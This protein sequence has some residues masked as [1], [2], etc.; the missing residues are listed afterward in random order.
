MHAADLMAML[1]GKHN[2]QDQ[3]L[4]QQLLTEANNVAESRGIA[5]TVRRTGSLEAAQKWLASCRSDA[6]IL[7]ATEHQLALSMYIDSMVLDWA[8]CV[9]IAPA[10]Q[11]SQLSTIP[12]RDHD[13]ATQSGSSTTA[14]QPTEQPT[15]KN[16]TQAAPEKTS[17]PAIAAFEQTIAAQ[18]G[19]STSAPNIDVPIPRAT[20]ESA[21]SANTQSAN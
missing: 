4:A 18:Q 17:D 13:E 10:M 2:H 6:K 1:S 15:P 12:Q 14:P 7:N 11:P 8:D 19:R 16:P 9:K 5:A 3:L 21:E 20:A